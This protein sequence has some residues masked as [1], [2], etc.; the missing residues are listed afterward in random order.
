MQTDQE[1]FVPRPACVELNVAAARRAQTRVAWN[2]AAALVKRLF[3]AL[4]AP[5]RMLRE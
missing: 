2:G 1:P 3:A 5:Y 4:R